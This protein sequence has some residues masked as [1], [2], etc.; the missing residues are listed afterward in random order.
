MKTTKL[1]IVSMCAAGTLFCAGL[2]AEDSTT[3]TNTGDST[4]ANTQK[5]CGKKGKFQR[6]GMMFKGMMEKMSSENPEKAKELAELRK[7][8]PEEFK[9]K[10]K[11]MM[12]EAMEKRK[13]EF[14][15]LK[16]LAQK[17]KE[18]NSEEYK[19]Q[20]Q[21]KLSEMFEKRVQ[22]QE[23]MLAKMQDRLE[24]MKEK[25]SETKS[26]KDEFIN[27]RMNSIINKDGKKGGGDTDKGDN[28]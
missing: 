19:S 14:Q 17:Y 5:S 4:Q 13:A 18:T 11:G 21:S 9:E 26:K 23:A 3:Q 27:K 24:K 8:N 10:V 16:N 1:A 12:K 6:N 20:L 2:S 22:T 7:T 25:I 15:E 28:A